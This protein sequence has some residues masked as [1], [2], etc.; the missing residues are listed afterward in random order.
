EP[1]DLRTLVQDVAARYDLALEHGHTL[2]VDL[3]SEPLPV[4][5][6]RGRLDQVL[7]NLLDNA[8]K[9][10]PRGGTVTLSARAE[11]RGVLLQVRDQGIGLPRESLEAIFV[12]FGRAPNAESAHLPGMGLG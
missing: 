10:A 9:Y 5:G 2:R 4:E 3:S 7:T 1:L 8:L 12:P 11:G 6:D